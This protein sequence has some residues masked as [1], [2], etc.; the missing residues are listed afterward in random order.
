MTENTVSFF[1]YSSTH[2]PVQVSS[3]TNFDVVCISPSHAP[4]NISNLFFEFELI[5]I[6]PIDRNVS[7]FENR[8]KKKITPPYYSSHAPYKISNQF[9]FRNGKV[10]PI[11]KVGWKGRSEDWPRYYQ[12][13]F[14][15]IFVRK[16]KNKILVTLD[17]KTKIKMYPLC[18]FFFYIGFFCDKKQ[19]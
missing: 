8:Q 12:F 2:I 13:Y 1:K 3:L 14:T 19:C 16:N 10:D 4:H 5:K 18:K 17:Y 7:I 6:H 9:F 11:I 15:W